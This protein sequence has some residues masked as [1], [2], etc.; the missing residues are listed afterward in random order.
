MDSINNLIIDLVKAAPIILT[1]LT[2]TVGLICSQSSGYY[3]HKH[4]T[5]FVTIVIMTTNNL[6]AIGFLPG[7]QTEIESTWSIAAQQS[8]MPQ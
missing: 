6:A 8:Q 3:N 5:T 4:R 7:L 2:A 1:L